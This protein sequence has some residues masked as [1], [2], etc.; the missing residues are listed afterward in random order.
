MGPLPAQFVRDIV[1][2][3]SALM[4]SLGMENLDSWG[5]GSSDGP[6]S[7]AQPG[8]GGANGSGSS[9]AS[10]SKADAAASGNE[11]GEKGPAAK[12]QAVSLQQHRSAALSLLRQRLGNLHG[13]KSSGSG[14]A[15]KEAPVVPAEPAAADEGASTAAAAAAAGEGDGTPAKAA[16]PCSPAMA[17]PAPP[18]A[19]SCSSSV[20]DTPFG[21][22][23]AILPSCLLHQGSDGAPAAAAAGCDGREAVAGAGGGGASHGL[24]SEGGQ[25]LEAKSE[26]HVLVGAP[27]QG[28]AGD[29]E[30]T[31]FQIE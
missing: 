14:S 31:L 27:S 1:G 28:E 18:S 19:S 22:P 26:G 17:T 7:S 9:G 21:T 15:D 16:R 11:Q 23:M 29:S 20:A 4:N 13:S 5:E 30:H 24:P 10:G 12:P 6:S 8:G 3:R 25:L 2:A